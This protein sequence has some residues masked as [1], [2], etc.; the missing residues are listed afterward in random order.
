MTLLELA[1]PYG[2]GNPQPRFAFGEHTVRSARIVGG[3]HVRC[4]LQSSDGARLD[5]IAFRS[6]NLP[7]GQL[8]LDANGRPIH[9]A[10]TLR[11]DTWGGRAKLELL[12]DDAFDPR[13]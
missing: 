1:G 8:L 13:Q 11:R 12:I 3:C 9:I 7:L 10:G 2:Q 5:A 4:V 6:G